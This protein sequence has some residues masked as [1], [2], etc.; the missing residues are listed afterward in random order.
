MTETKAFPAVILGL[1]LIVSAAVFGFFYNSAQ[2]VNSKDVL[3]VTGSTKTRVTSDQAKLVV[4]L[5]RTVRQEELSGGKKEV[6]R[7]L[8]L[9]RNLLQD[10]GIDMSGI[11]E[12]PLSM[13]QAYDQY[14][15]GIVRY[16]FSQSVTVQSADVN[17]ITEISKKIPDLVDQGALVSIQSLEYYYSKLPDLRVS[18]LT[19]AV[20]D[21][22]VRADKI[23]GGTGRKVGGVQS[24]SIGVVQVLSPN[25]VDISDYGNYDTSSVEK[26]VM[27][28]VKAT[29][30]LE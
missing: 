2:A 15:T 26:D 8:G 30:R 20:K 3:A 19:E 14:N 4:S 5:N 10:S 13:Y 11:T 1:A 27:V 25:S 18:L 23:A 28:T 24:A 12:S 6:A 22:K 16:Q 29:F 7:D 9:V 21:A 17:K